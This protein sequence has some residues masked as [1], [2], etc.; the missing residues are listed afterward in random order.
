MFSSYNSKNSILTVAGTYIT[1]KA[2]DFWAF[3]KREALAEDAEG[4]D[5]DVVRNVKNSNIWDAE[6]TVQ[7]TSPQANF[8]FSLMNREEP[9]AIW[10]EDKALGRREGGS[11]ALMN[12][13]PEDSRGTAAGDLTFKFSVYDG[14]ITEI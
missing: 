6:V 10:C 13:A 5:G 7:A 8:L 12:E 1:G 2:E 11:K 14:E 4:A 3:A 9:F